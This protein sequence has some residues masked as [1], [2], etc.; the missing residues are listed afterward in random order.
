MRVLLLPALAGSLLVMTGLV[1]CGQKGP[2][3]IP[4]DTDS[5]ETNPLTVPVEQPRLGTP[6]TF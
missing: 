3:Y 6:T 4:A 2:L 5:K 1:G